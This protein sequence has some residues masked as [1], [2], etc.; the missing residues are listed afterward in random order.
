MALIDILL[1]IFCAFVLP[2]ALI[3]LWLWAGDWL[4]MLAYRHK[5]RQR[6]EW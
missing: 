4:D 2:Y 6:G 3:K 1:F 5:R